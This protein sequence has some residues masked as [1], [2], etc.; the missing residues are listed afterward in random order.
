MPLGVETLRGG[1]DRDASADPSDPLEGPGEEL[2]RHHEDQDLGVTHGFAGIASRFDAG[3]TVDVLQVEGVAA[4]RPHSVDDLSRAGP[5]ADGG[6]RP[7]EV[8][9][10]PHAPAATADDADSQRHARRS[11]RRRSVPAKSR[12]MFSW[13]RTITMAA[14]A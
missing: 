2:G 3:W 10:Q 8:D 13:W 12:P 5:E 9:R 11:P 6:A 1:N 4:R 14:P 7:R